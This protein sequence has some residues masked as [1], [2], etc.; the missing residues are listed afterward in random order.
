[1]VQERETELMAEVDSRQRH[2]Q[3]LQNQMAALKGALEQIK[4]MA[5]LLVIWS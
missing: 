1:M 2:I 4:K 5:S 3:D